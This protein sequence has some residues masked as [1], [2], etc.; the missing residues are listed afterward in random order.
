MGRAVHYSTRL[1]ELAK[2]NV[3]RKRLSR[4]LRVMT[5]PRILSAVPYRLGQ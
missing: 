3:L 4:I 2:N 1:M 5:E